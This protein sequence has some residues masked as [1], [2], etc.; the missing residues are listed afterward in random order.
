MHDLSKVKIRKLFEAM[1]QGSL[2]EVT[3]ET[4]L[5][6][7]ASKQERADVS[8]LI[9]QDKSGFYGIVTDQDFTRKAIKKGLST[10][11]TPVKEIMTPA[12]KVLTV[13][14]DDPIQKA[15]EI[16][17]KKGKRHIPIMVSDRCVGIISIKN[18]YVVQDLLD[19][20]IDG[21]ISTQ[22]ET[23]DTLRS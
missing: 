10:D 3:P 14:L 11:S 4:F 9:V 5:D 8:S 2:V 6:A 1:K 20:I 16:V 22:T 7:C 17:R 23:V 21:E 13:A 19:F 15:V 12:A 18:L